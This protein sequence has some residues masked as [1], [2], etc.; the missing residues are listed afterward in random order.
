MNS[1]HDI[2]TPCTGRASRHSKCARP[3]TQWRRRR[4]RRQGA[5]ILETAI[6]LSLFISLVLGMVD[7]G[8]GV[9]RQHVL[10]QATRQLARQAIVRGRLADR[11]TSWGP[12]KISITADETHDVTEFIAP[13][14]I[15]WNRDE[16]KIE[17]EWPDGNNDFREGNRVHVQMTAPYRPTL[18]F[19][20]GRLSM[21]LH[22]SSTMYVAH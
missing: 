19:I 14:L 16:V 2:S 12:E 8:Y 13:K 5:A 9:F 21:D 7:L 17:I 22:A 10:S 3:S 1:R 6:A 11:I 4:R 20:L 18:A 15:G